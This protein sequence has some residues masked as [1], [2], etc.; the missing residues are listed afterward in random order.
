MKTSKTSSLRVKA[1]AY[2]SINITGDE[3]L[4]N[5]GAKFQR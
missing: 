2:Y 5:F 1:G 3:L 4:P